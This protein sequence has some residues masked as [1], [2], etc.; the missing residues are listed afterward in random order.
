MAAAARAA[1]AKESLA[2][3]W[4]AAAEAWRADVT[5][6]RARACV[7]PVSR[8]LP[9]ATAEYLAEK[10]PLASWLP[11]YDYRWLPRDAVAGITVGVMLIPQG[12][13]YAKIATIP[14]ENGLYSSWLPSV[15]Y[16][17]LGT[18]RGECAPPCP[19]GRDTLADTS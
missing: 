18:S 2:G 17:F 9:S 11:H 10:L 6:S 19:R 3:A 7:G 12:L 16:L 14:V 5:L 15:L 13:A 4:A 8:R 1:R